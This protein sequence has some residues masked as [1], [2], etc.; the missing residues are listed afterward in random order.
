MRLPV[1]TAQYHGLAHDAQLIACLI[2]SRAETTPR[3]WMVGE[4]LAAAFFLSKR[5][6][7]QTTR[8]H[9][10]K[11]LQ[12]LVNCYKGSHEPSSNI[13]ETNGL[14]CHVTGYVSQIPNL[15]NF[16]CPSHPE[17]P[18]LNLK[19]MRI[20]SSPPA[21][22]ARG[23][24][25]PTRTP[26]PYGHIDRGAK[27]T[28]I[29]SKSC[30]SAALYRNPALRPRQSPAVS[31]RNSQTGDEVDESNERVTYSIPHRQP[32]QPFSRIPSQ[33][34][35]SST[36]A[37]TLRRIPKFEEKTIPRRPAAYRAA[38]APAI[39][40]ASPL[41]SD[42]GEGSTTP[43][44]PPIP[45]DSSY[46]PRR[47]T[48]ISRRTES[49]ILYALEEAIRTPN[50]FT[51]DL[52]EEN[53]SMADLGIG[54]AQNG[55]S[56]TAAGPVPVPTTPAARAM[57][58]TEIMRR[59]RDREAR[60]RAEIEA[61]QRDEDEELLRIQE[62]K[63]I[64]AERRA[65]TT[66]GAV[67]GPS[68]VEPSSRRESGGGRRSGGDQIPQDA[69]DRRLSERVA[70]GSAPQVNTASVRASEYR[71]S[72]N[73]A[74]EARNL[75]QPGSR[76]RAAS[77]SQPLPRPVPPQTSRAA[78]ATYSTQQLPSQTR[79]TSAGA[80]TTQAQAAPSVA[81]SFQQARGPQSGTQSRNANTSNFPHAFE[82]WETLS[83]H[84]EGLTSYWIN[85]LDVNSD[86]LKGQPLNQQLARQVTDLSAA[87][88]NLFHA[89]VE[90]QRLRASSERKFQR[91]FYETRS[92]Q[93]RFQE[94]IAESEIEIRTLRQAL[95]EATAG[96]V[97]IDAEK[98]AGD[99]AEAEEVKRNAE[100]MV[101]EMR[102]ELQIS[103]DEAR[104]GWEEIGRM[105][106]AE[107]DRTASLRNGERTLVGG[108]EVVPMLHGGTSRQ[109][110]TNR[111]STRDGPL[112]GDTGGL[113]GAQVQ[114]PLESPGIGYT[115]YDPARSETDTD[116]FT[117][118]GND[119]A[120]QA[121]PRMAPPSSSMSQPYQQSSTTAA[122]AAVQA[123]RSAATTSHPVSP[124]RSAI[125]PSSARQPAAGGTYLSYRPA[126][127]GVQNVSGPFYQQQGT[128][129]ALLQ[130]G[131]SQQRPQT[132]EGDERSYVQSIDETLSEEEYAYDGQGNVRLDAEGRPIM[133]HHVSGS[134]DS[135]E[136]NVQAQLDRE[137]LYGAQYG[138]N[139]TGAE[140]GS[141]S[142]ASAAPRGRDQ[143]G[144]TGTTN[145]QST[146]GAAA[147]APVA[148]DG[149]G[150]GW[151]AVPRHHHPTRLS[152]VLEE[153]ER[154]RASPSR[155]SE[156][157]RGLH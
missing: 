36:S 7:S 67:G 130:E 59:R 44:A 64:S 112:S 48:R 20:H 149:T 53:A 78:S 115:N 89:V 63:R 155:A 65:A 88:A 75:Q 79:L 127:T 60:E 70:S 116:P 21:S 61:R 46:W 99:R 12:H 142:T 5:A 144:G 66:G 136:Y 69:S 26:A 150:Y 114:E 54:R 134:E 17:I 147:Q 73:L 83:S 33:K 120:G 11:P 27:G 14:L 29:F 140:Y 86:E 90:L 84:W 111:P 35:S 32:R 25:Y 113:H 28:S 43:G 9:L 107:R 1:S 51:S 100:Q 3:E 156:R 110:S 81:P 49:A 145:G 19:T 4:A 30:T 153:D 74:P 13:C 15:L 10:S 22:S 101:K 8:D 125:A 138:S 85:R 128:G 94:R 55:G 103:R 57:T 119:Q 82:R 135:D 96:K 40:I 45:P 157:S 38:A 42:E 131:S 102:R 143:T 106:Q 105:E 6:S 154:S 151:E 139:A 93:E 71:N 16:Y 77:A 148:Y 34:S 129:T 98:I 80:G 123:A 2:A 68:R 132:T 133:Y 91:W 95:A 92:E 121:L 152:D 47:S 109:P 146:H 41:S 37:H 104:R 62:E 56:R 87:G 72:S 50:L 24:F 52:V 31:R 76:N 23:F 18:S 39:Q 117:E 126:G 118:N 108:V 137:R 58:P 141:G 124:Q 97:H 122:A